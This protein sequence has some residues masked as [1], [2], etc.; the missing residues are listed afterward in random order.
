[1]TVSYPAYNQTLLPVMFGYSLSSGGCRYGTT[2]EMK[3]AV[4]KVIDTLT[5][6]DFNGPSISCWNGTTI[7]LQPDEITLKRTRVSCVYY[8]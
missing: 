3:E 6:E 5:Q 2:V 1:M 4:T 8:Q 7:A